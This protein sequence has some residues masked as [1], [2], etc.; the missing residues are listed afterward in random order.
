MPGLFSAP[1]L[2]GT[3]PSAVKKRC[4]MVRLQTIEAQKWQKICEGH[5]ISNHT[6]THAA[7]S[8]PLFC[9]ILLT[10][11]SIYLST[12]PKHG[13]A[14]EHAFDVQF[15]ISQIMLFFLTE[16]RLLLS[17]TAIQYYLIEVWNLYILF[18]TSLA[19]HTQTKVLT[20]SDTRTRTR[21]YWILSQDNAKKTGVPLHT[22]TIDCDKR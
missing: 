20:F 1:P 4:V 8:I 11:I 22:H 6:H 12:L 3:F 15:Q 17:F 10:T 2:V 13:G 18:A 14:E 7:H 9:C 19:H 5:P 21:V 16:L